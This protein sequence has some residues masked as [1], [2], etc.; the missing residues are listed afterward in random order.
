MLDPPNVRGYWIGLT[1]IANEGLYAW[2]D[3]APMDTNI[4][5]VCLIF[6]FKSKFSV[7]GLPSFYHLFT[8]TLIYSVKQEHSY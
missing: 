6:I 8:A 7:R 3:G 1:D 5:L 2:T 4:M